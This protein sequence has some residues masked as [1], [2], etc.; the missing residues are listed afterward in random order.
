VTHAMYGRSEQGE[1]PV[2]AHHQPDFPPPR[3]RRPPSGLA[4]I[5]QAA[6]RL[7]ADSA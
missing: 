3:Y 2:C 1:Y 6:H 4:P 7:S 5:V